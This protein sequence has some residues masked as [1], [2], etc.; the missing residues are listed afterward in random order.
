M[1]LYEGCVENR[2]DPLKLG[3]CQVRVVGL[4]THDKNILSTADLPWA[5][6]LQPVTSAAISGLGHSPVGPVE[7]TWVIIMFRILL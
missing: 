7:G 6:P 5:Y 2:N 3:R 4:H 1:K